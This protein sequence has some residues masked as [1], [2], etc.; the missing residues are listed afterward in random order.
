MKRIFE[1]ITKNTVKL[2]GCFIP[3]WV[4]QV[5]TTTVK[6]NQRPLSFGNDKRGCQLNKLFLGGS[7]TSAEVGWEGGQELRGRRGIYG[8]GVGHSGV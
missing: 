8:R 3:T 4:F 2:F 1:I 5:L 6:Q 7:G